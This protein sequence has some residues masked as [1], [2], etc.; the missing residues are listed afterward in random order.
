MEL[1]SPLVLWV[2]AGTT[3]LALA[4]ATWSLVQKKVPNL[5][6]RLASNG[7]VSPGPLPQVLQA[8]ER[9]LLLIDR[10]ALPNMLQ[11][12]S[13]DGLSALDLQFIL[14]K[15]IREE[16][17]YNVTQ[18]LYLA[19]ATWNAVQSL[20]EKNL[21]WIRSVAAALPAGASANDL[22]KALLLTYYSHG[23]KPLHELVAAAVSHDAQMLLKA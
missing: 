10:M 22:H 21:Q 20:K 8:H 5:P 1:T 19:P 9:I 4:L 18:Q 17:D 7:A 6:A 13:L 12:L 23:D 16:F 3:L 11:K 14:V 15:T 2:L